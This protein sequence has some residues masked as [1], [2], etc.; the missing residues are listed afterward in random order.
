MAL[1][2]CT[3]CNREISDKASKCPGC[4]IIISQ[5]EEPKIVEYN[6]ESDLFF[7]SM[8]LLVKLAMRAIQENGWTLEQ[9]NDSIGLITF[10][11]SISWGSWSGVSCSLNISFYQLLF[12]LLDIL[13]IH[14]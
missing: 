7:G 13:H 11:T 9:A 12:Y 10:K 8:N 14:L 1:I 3:E 2:K 5:K 4:G 6:S